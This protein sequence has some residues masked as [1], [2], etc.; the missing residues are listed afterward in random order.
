MRLTGRL[1]LTFCLTAGAIALSI[2]TSLAC[3]SP[4]SDAPRS[5]NTPAL[6]FSTAPPLPL[7]S[8]AEI[9]QLQTDLTTGMNNWFGLAGLDKVASPPIFSDTHQQ[10]QA[11]WAQVDLDIAS[12]LGFWHDGENFPYTLGIFPSATPGEVCILE[13][14]PE[15]SLEIF[16][17]VTGEYGKDVITEQILSFSRATVQAG[18]LRSGEIR[19]VGSAIALSRYNTN[20]I[21][22][23]GLQDEVGMVRVVAAASPPT[24]PDRLPP[25]ILAAAWQMLADQGCE[26]PDMAPLQ[27]L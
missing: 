13:F 16:N 6:T 5:A 22:L 27:G 7:L 25:D 17:E 14:K 8:A 19:T 9:T 24:F 4:E 21:L 20:P 12:F 26:Q 10:Y 2:V 11:R 23:I 15:W 1:Y 18:Q 3:E